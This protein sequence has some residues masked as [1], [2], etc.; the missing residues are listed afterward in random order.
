VI[1]IR[2]TDDGD[3]V[4][5]VES[6]F[7]VT[8]DTDAETFDRYADAV[9]S[10]QRGAPY[11][12]ALFERYVTLAAESTDREMAVEN[13]DWDDP[14][15]EP[16]ETET[17]AERSS[18]RELRVGVI[19]YSFTWTNF[20]VVD[21]DRIHVGDAFRTDDGILLRTLSDGQRLVI[22]PPDNYGFVDAP[23]STDD[24]M[25]VWSGPR[26][27]AADGLEIT[28][29]RGAGGPGSS[30]TGWLFSSAGWVIAAVLGLV[31][32]GTGGLLVRRRDDRSL[33]LPSLPVF[34][35]SESETDRSDGQSVATDGSTASDATTAMAPSNATAEVESGTRLEFDEDVDP[36]LL[37]DEERVLRLLKRNGGRMKQASIV[38]ETG[39]SNA[40][41]SQLLSAMDEDG[42]IDKLRIGR[43]NLITLPGVDP[44]EVD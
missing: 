19:S 38:T 44:T 9:V 20:A 2:V 22:E 35:G 31:L 37:S 10:G 33:E 26:Q 14:R 32:V 5:T 28:I 1:R 16:L 15:I 34:G 30:A 6:R 18:D 21:G 23:T 3:A 11:D 40:K 27:F 43:E 7:L 25:L 12:P 4:W 42:E 41:V 8:N 29:L 17:D 39:W 24:G 13:A 36:E